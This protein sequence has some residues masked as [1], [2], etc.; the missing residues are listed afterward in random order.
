MT[1]AGSWC[2]CRQGKDGGAEP[3]VSVAF[4]P[5]FPLLSTEHIGTM[6][7]GKFLLRPLCPSIP[8]LGAPRAVG[9][10]L[11][12][13]FSL[14]QRCMPNPGA[15]TL[16]GYPC[17]S[18]LPHPSRCP[19]PAPSPGIPARAPLS[20][21]V[22]PTAGDTGDRLHSSHPGCVPGTSPSSRMLC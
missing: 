16:A 10:T 11:S 5:I 4:L 13:G 14:P 21:S 6:A 1:P 7:S 18:T 9:A 3:P 19:A 15:C 17:C 22:N 20:T 12:P 8:E 2:R